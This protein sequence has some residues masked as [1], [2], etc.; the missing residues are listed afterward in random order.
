MKGDAAEDPNDRRASEEEPK[1]DSLL[2]EKA[3]VAGAWNVALQHSNDA[4]IRESYRLSVMENGEEPKSDVMDRLQTQIQHNAIA[5]EE[6]QKT[7]F[8]QSEGKA[9]LD[10]EQPAS[11][12]KGDSCT[13]TPLPPG[14]DR[15]NTPGAIA[16][17]G[18]QSQA[19]TTGGV[20]LLDNQTTVDMD[21][22]ERVLENKKDSKE[23]D[24]EEASHLVN[25]ELVQE[26]P[27]TQV[28]ATTAVRMSESDLPLSQRGF[29]S[30][31]RDRRVCCLIC[32]F[33][34]VL[35]LLA[36][37]LSAIFLNRSRMMRNGN[38]P[39]SSGSGPRSNKLFGGSN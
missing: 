4:S 39:P 1:R 2:E 34:C 11:I 15:R 19:E 17:V 16:M 32:A 27:I 37:V 30:V 38:G 10:E 36:I 28:T 26:E 6:S 25:A 14:L 13:K 29:R 18:I 22:S 20:A 3:K 35:V 9:V 5:E 8:L 23:K 7:K 24:E 33:I 21:K 12:S 31:M